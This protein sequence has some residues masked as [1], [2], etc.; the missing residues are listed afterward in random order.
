MAPSG[1]CSCRSPTGARPR[2]AV[3]HGDD[4]IDREALSRWTRSLDDGH[5]LLWEEHPERRCLDAL[6]PAWR[7]GVESIVVL[8]YAGYFAR[9][10]T[11]RHFAV[12]KA[13][14]DDPVLYDLALSTVVG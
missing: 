1:W 9:R 10:I 14:R 8:P 2:W 6:I 12:S 5:T 13:T 11:R 4:G 7:S 3:E